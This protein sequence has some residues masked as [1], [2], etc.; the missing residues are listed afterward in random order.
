MV[1]KF[2]LQKFLLERD[3]YDDALKTWNGCT[4]ARK[5]VLGE[6]WFIHEGDRLESAS[7]MNDH[8]TANS[9]SLALV[10]SLSWI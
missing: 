6:E 8:S 4:Q 3:G 1:V 9:K 7:A 5:T 10:V 2:P